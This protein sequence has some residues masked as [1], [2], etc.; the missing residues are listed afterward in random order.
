VPLPNTGAGDERRHCSRRLTPHRPS[1]PAERSTQCTTQRTDRPRYLV[2]YS[3]GGSGMR[4]YDA[5][6]DI[7]AELRDGGGRYRV[8]HVEHPASRSCWATPTASP[9]A[10]RVQA[11]RPTVT[12]CTPRSH[13]RGPFSLDGPRAPAM[14][15]LGLWLGPF[16]GVGDDRE[17]LLL[18][19]SGH[20]VA[21][22]C[23]S[24]GWMSLSWAPG[25]AAGRRRCRSSAGGSWRMLRDRFRFARTRRRACGCL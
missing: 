23:R 15:R 7:G 6:L 10:C 21:S 2:H 18:A 13:A 17:E 25:S 20:K 16:D 8:V 24:L 22:R 19:E 9:R 14:P 12:N 1:G 5:L 3:N 11:E 4:R